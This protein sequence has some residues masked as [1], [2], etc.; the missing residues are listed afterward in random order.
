M[1]NTAKKLETETVVLLPVKQLHKSPTQPRRRGGDKPDDD[2]VASIREKGVIQPI[3]ARLRPAGGWEIVFG[4]RRHAG[5]ILADLETIPA[6]VRDLSDEDVFE[7]QLIENIHRQDMHPLDEADG[8]KRM[9]DKGKKTIQQI[10]DAIGRPAA[11][12]A[13]RLKLCELSSQVRTALDKDS[14]SLGVAIVLA[15]IPSSLQPEALKSLWDGI[16]VSEAKRRLDDTYLMRLDQAAFDVADAKLV[17]KAGACTACPKRTGQ[18]KDLF[19]DI[20]SPDLCIDRVCYRGKLDAVWLIRKKEAAAGGTAVLEGKPAQE[21]AQGYSHSYRRLDDSEWVGNAQKK[22]RAILG[23]DLPPISLVRDERSGTILE[24]VKRADV[25]KVLKRNSPR[26]TSG[27]RN[28]AEKRADAKDRIRSAAMNL[29]MAS[30]VDHI[31]NLNAA[32]LVKLLVVVLARRTWN[33]TQQA[34]ARRRGLE[35]EKTDR[36]DYA[37]SGVEQ[38]LIAHLGKLNPAGVA[39]LGAELALRQVG[40]SRNGSAQP[41]FGE[42][43]KAMGLDFA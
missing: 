22:V 17:E 5:S 43:M 11:H 26:T 24:V 34:V 31:G 8:F 41:I 3:V 27:G 21:V 14:I 30:V 36:R 32:K 35:K 33:D 10:A 1:A 18:Q 39:G 40:P 38:R 4:H 16:S 19:A 13:Q 7:A 2:F 6:I 29:A 15:R 12:V 25:D 28:D 20:K 42:T 23:K 37:T 9:M